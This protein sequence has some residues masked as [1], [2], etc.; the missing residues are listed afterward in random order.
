MPTMF[1]PRRI[2]QWSLA[3]IFV[4]LVALPLFQQIA[5]TPP[6]RPLS[7]IRARVR[8]FPKWTF[9]AWR[10]GIFA[11]ETDSWI[12]DNV[13]FRGYLISINRQIRYSLFGS[14]EVPPLR[15]RALVVGRKPVLFENILLVDA[16]RPPQ[17]SPE[18][19]DAFGFRLARMQRLLR[20]QGMA[21]LVI[22]APNKAFLYP[23]DLPSWAR[24]RVAET[25][26]SDHVA[27]IDAL[28]RHGV[29][30]LDS[31]AL[32]RK[33]GLRDMVPPH[34]IHW[35]NH[36]AWVAWQE[37]IPAINAQS[38]LPAIPVPETVDMVEA[39]PT[40][41]NDELRAQ[42]NL[43]FAAHGKPVPSLYPV[44]GPV[45]P[46]CEGMLRVLIVGD[47]FGFTLA[48]ALARSRLCGDIR[49]WFYMKSAKVAVPASYDSREKR[50]LDG[51]AGIGNLTGSDSGGRRML[52]N[53]NLV[54]LAITTFNIDKYTWGFDRLINRLY[55]DPADNLPLGEEI[56]EVNLGD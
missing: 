38:L 33:N 1:L 9:K 49:Y 53:R 24:D 41:M 14:V 45:P 46:E 21:F 50:V 28:R 56:V 34:G 18:T 29:H 36:G 51:V 37:A 47:S 25:P 32:F 35:S 27:F 52:E 39:R 26:L 31:M 42:L 55:G 7:G 20:E 17:I 19:M 22:L 40:A 16:L 43:F 2:F 54:I 10:R 4:A 8:E 44:A 12:R 13:G 11:A 6:D 30:H 48:D 5:K 3:T 15:K 23:D